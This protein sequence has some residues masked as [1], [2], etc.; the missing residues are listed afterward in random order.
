MEIVWK[1]LNE[2][3]PYWNNPRRNEQAVAAVAASIKEFGFQNPIIVDSSYTI[4][5]GHTRLEAAKQ[6]RL[7]KVPCLIADGLTPEQVRAFRLADN[8]TAEL[9]DWDYPKLDSELAEIKL[10]M[11]SFGFDLQQD[12]ISDILNDTFADLQTGE[13]DKFSMTFIFRSENKEAL[14]SYIKKFGKEK[15]VDVIIGEVNKNA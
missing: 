11:S 3:K 8:K 4:I 15:I 14:D 7:D 12:F 2:V 9:S 5:A 6:L 10:D 1:L 13:A